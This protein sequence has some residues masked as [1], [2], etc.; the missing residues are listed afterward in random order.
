MKNFVS[1]LKAL[2]IAVLMWIGVYVSTIGALAAGF[3]FSL[4]LLM[5]GVVVMFIGAILAATMLQR[6]DDKWLRLAL[7]LLLSG[8]T[9]IAVRAM[10]GITSIAWLKGF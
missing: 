10:G 5:L 9:V 2:L 3:T 8:G 7:V 1:Y 4:I 6:S